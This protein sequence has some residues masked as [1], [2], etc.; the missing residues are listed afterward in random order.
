MGE[1]EAGTAACV[2]RTRG[3]ASLP[4]LASVERARGLASPPSPMP[5][6]EAT[7]C[8]DPIFRIAASVRRARGLASPPILA[9]V[10][11]VRGLVPVLWQQSS[12]ARQG[13]E[14]CRFATILFPVP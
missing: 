6:A 4:T 11:R 1:R 5:Q 10:E 2:E 12:M 8:S 7:D 13:V 14:M 3:L 9:S